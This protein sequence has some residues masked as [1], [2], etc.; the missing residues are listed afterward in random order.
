MVPPCGAPSSV[1]NSRPVSVNPHC[2]HFFKD[3]CV[4]GNGFQQPFVTDVVETAL[5]VTLQYPFRGFC[6]VQIGKAL[7]DCIV[8]T[9]R[10]V[11]KSRA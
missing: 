7:L 11:K 8:R 10:T 9:S 4:D 1:G 6:F 3:L 5:D 2:S